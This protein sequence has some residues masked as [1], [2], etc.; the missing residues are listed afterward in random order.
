MFILVGRKE[1]WR[2]MAAGEVGGKWKSMRVRQNNRVAWKVI[3]WQGNN[4]TLSS[5]EMTEFNPDMINSD[6]KLW[7]WS[8]KSNGLIE[9]KWKT[10]FDNSAYLWEREILK[11]SQWVEK[12]KIF[13]CLNPMNLKTIKWIRYKILSFLSWLQ[14]KKTFLMNQY[15][16]TEYLSGNTWSSPC[17]YLTH[18]K[19]MLS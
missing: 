6:M 15:R 7:K 2:I 5:F 1:N 14:V 10:E 3:I 17:L 9:K 18:E 4:D 12:S 16:C 8:F 13:L 19:R 11:S